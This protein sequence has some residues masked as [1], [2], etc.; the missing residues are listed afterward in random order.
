MDTTERPAT[1]ALSQSD[2]DA[3]R[4]RARA[5]QAKEPRAVSARYD[6]RVGRVVVTLSNGLEL[7][8]RPHDA[9]GLEGAKPAQ[10]AS[11]EISPSGQGL[12]FPSLDADLSVAGL[13]R[14]LFGSAD[15]MSERAA[16]RRVASALGSVGGKARSPA[17]SEAAR[18]NG[19]LGGRPRK[20]APPDA[21][22]T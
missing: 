4:S 5:D 13:L 8:F 18:A 22:G 14:G 15:W 21:A 10:L 3:A 20:P 2:I 11:I 6:R 12:H 1:A 16:A 17:K 9:Q 19:K 7:G